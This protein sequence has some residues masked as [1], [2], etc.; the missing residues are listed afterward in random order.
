MRVQFFNLKRG[1]LVIR[2]VHM[3]LFGNSAYLSSLGDL[4]VMSLVIF[5]KFRLTVFSEPPTEYVNEST[6]KTLANEV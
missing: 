1:H 3:C 2:A 6:N 4:S 5:V